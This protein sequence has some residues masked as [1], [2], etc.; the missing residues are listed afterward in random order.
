[1]IQLSSGEES[2]RR[3]NK[4]ILVVFMTMA[5]GPARYGRL[6]WERCIAWPG[7]LD[8]MRHAVHMLQAGYSDLSPWDVHCTVSF[9][10]STSCPVRMQWT[11]LI[12][13]EPGKADDK[14]GTEGCRKTF[15]IL[16]EGR[17]KSTIEDQQAGHLEQCL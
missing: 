13:G 4:N 12:V 5:Q 16:V 7:R 3:E 10:V 17:G 1:M 9:L 8:W 2:P 14:S 11:L 15:Y 6:G